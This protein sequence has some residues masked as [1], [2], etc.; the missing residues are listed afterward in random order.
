MKKLIIT[1]TQQLLAS[2]LIL[3]VYTLSLGD[4]IFGT[5]RL[6]IPTWLSLLFFSYARYIYMIFSLG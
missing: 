4:I 1:T 6:H 2:I 3:D 5:F